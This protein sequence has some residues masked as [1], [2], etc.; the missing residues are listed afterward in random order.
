[1]KGL[2]GRAAVVT[3]AG[4]GIGRAIAAR[5]AA[6]GVSVAVNDV[7]AAAAAAAAGEIQAAGG[8]AT[9]A[10]GDVSRDADARTIVRACVDAFGR[11]DILVNNAGVDVSAPVSET[12]DQDWQRVH[13]VDLFGP[14]L[15]VRAAEAALAKQKGSVITIASNHAIATIPDRT[16]YAAA[17]AGAVG[18]TRALAMEL[19]PKGIRANAVLPGYIRTPIWKLWL[20]KVADQEGL[21]RRIASRHPIRR[22][23]TP[24]DVAGVV[25][26]LASDDAGFM[27]GA[28]IVVDGGY[29]QQLEAPEA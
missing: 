23:G 12:T 17:K 1:M 15:L 9:A 14:F 19:G 25:A 28:T 10:A 18:L 3:G 29:S 11:L 6:E 22:L 8:K 20:D 27:T 5:L 16:A 2:T 24:E 26:F 13:A 4:Q 21:L 7:D